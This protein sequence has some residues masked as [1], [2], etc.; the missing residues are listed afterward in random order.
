MELI[1]GGL[2]IDWFNN[3]RLFQPI[4]DVPPAEFEMTL[5]RQQEESAMAAW[6]KQT[7]VRYFRDDSDRL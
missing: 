7:S 2:Q 4:G 5:Y 1:R 6:L 3:L